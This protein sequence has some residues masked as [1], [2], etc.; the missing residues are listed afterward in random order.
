MPT[1]TRKLH[2][3]AAQV[4]DV[5][6]PAGVLF[7]EK[8]DEIERMRREIALLR[9][10]ADRYMRARGEV[11]VDGHTRAQYVLQRNAALVHGN[12]LYAA[13][14]ECEEA[15]GHDA[16]HWERAKKA[17]IAWDKFEGNFN[18]KEAERAN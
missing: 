13:L 7:R 5:L 6:N 17:L 10:M 2:E 3:A 18:Y 9:P 1:R 12:E 15:D 8:N 4:R 11:K 16:P 14:Q